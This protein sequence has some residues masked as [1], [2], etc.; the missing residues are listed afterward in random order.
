VVSEASR[1]VRV[2]PVLGAVSGPEG[3][4]ILEPERRHWRIAA[5][6]RRPAAWRTK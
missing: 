6:K 2:L 5:V 1:D 3:W 4:N